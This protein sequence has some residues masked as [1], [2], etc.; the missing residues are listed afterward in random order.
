MENSLSG[1][2]QVRKG[3]HTGEIIG[4]TLGIILFSTTIY[5]MSLAIKAHRLTIKKLN[6]EGYK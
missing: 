1:I 5:A 2:K 6:N 4:F 3:A